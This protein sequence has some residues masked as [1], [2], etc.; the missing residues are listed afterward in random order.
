LNPES[1]PDSNPDSN[2]DPDSN[3]GSNPDSGPDPREATFLDPEPQLPTFHPFL[4]YL[5]SISE[6]ILPNNWKSQM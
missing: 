1:D 3:P 5:L 6:I 2:L 4:D